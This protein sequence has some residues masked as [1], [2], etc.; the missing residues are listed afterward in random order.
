MI[1]LA[2]RVGDDLAELQRGAAGGVFLEAVVTLD[3]F[4][5]DAG[6]QILERL[7]GDLA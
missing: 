1:G 7:G 3:D 2:H 5:V 6:G 4:D